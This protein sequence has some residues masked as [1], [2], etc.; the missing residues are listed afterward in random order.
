[1]K[2]EKW[3]VYFKNEVIS[4]FLYEILGEE[5]NDIKRIIHQ[6]FWKLLLL[7]KYFTKKH[8]FECW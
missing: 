1:M 3:E 2:Y 4:D 7:F 6:F 8:D 5:Q